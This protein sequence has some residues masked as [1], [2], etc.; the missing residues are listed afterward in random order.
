MYKF[1]N[2]HYNFL[3][4][5]IH[6][7]IYIYIYIKQISY[8]WHSTVQIDSFYSSVVSSRMWLPTHCFDFKIMILFFSF[9]FFL[10]QAFWDTFFI[11]V[12][13]AHW[14]WR[15]KEQIRWD[16]RLFDKSRWSCCWERTY[17]SAGWFLISK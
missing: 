17:W 7:K 10:F 16:K 5:K 6:Q 3:T 1:L 13:Y 12:I 9:F 15:N 14:K 4:I 2:L 11:W 8:S